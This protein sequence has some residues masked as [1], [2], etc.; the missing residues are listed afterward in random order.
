MSF[1][2]DD[3]DDV[4]LEHSV[5]VVS[6]VLLLLSRFSRG[7]QPSR[8]PRLMMMMMLAQSTWLGWYPLHYSTI[9]L[10]FPLG[11]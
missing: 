6:A 1:I 8:L 7:L 10:H 5:R 2:T 9:K 4:G 11:D 3:D